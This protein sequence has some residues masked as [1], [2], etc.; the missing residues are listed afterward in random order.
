MKMSWST[1]WG[2]FL[3]GAI[4][5]VLGGRGGKQQVLPA[6]GVQGGEGEEGPIQ[7]RKK[8]DLIQRVRYRRE[9]GKAEK[10][11]SSTLKDQWVTWTPWISGSPEG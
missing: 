1:Q 7:V 9:K 6:V 10:E 2:I 5:Q 8:A 3:S 11:I 4:S